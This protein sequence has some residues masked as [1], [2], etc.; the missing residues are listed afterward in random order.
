M[1]S[2]CKLGLNFEDRLIF[3]V[4][5]GLPKLI[6]TF[7]YGIV[8]AFLP[9]DWLPHKDVREQTVLITGAA[10]G[11]GRLLAVKFASLGCKLV[12]WDINNLGNFET[13]EMC[14]KYDV[15][16]SAYTVDITNTEAVEKT[17]S[18]VLNK[19]GSVDIL[20]NNAGIVT[21]K[22]LL[23]CPDETFDLT[24]NVNANSLFY[25]T[26]R[27]LPKMI[28]NDRGHIV[29]VASMA[30]RI[31]VNGLVDYSA[32]KF[33]ACGFTEALHAELTS[34]NSNVKTTL[35]CPY[36]VNTGMFEGVKSSFPNL[37]PILEPEY[38]RDQIVEAVLTDTHIVYMPR[39][40]YFTMVIKELFSVYT[41]DAIA[42][43][44]GVHQ[45]MAGFKGR[46]QIAT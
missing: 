13:A 34:T 18:L 31:G 39:F 26:K 23:D 29:V 36:Y 7:F 22:K 38:V 42:E 24:M 27:F 17:A 43:I 3:H 6:F 20:I 28:A 5:Q 46:K 9:W 37:L 33:A 41:G 40:C 10:S 32:S 4:L 8:R 16:V 25:V 12:L 14:K 30:G 19:F 2:F 44:C 1:I 11:V 15:Q 21:G 45:Q 35:I